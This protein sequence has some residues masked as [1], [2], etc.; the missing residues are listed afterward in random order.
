MKKFGFVF[1][2]FVALF[3]APSLSSSLSMEELEGTLEIVMITETGITKTASQFIM[4][5]RMGKGIEFSPPAN[6]PPMSPNKK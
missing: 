4:L 2:V 5:M 3:V 6:A 1:T